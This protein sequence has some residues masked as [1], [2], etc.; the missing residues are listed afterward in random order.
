MR[1]ALCHHYS[2][3]FQ[4][5]GERFLLET[6]RQLTKRGHEVAIYALPFGKRPVN[7]LEQLEGIEYHENLM[8][9][10]RDVDIGYFI[11]APL[12]SR[13]FRGQFPRIGAL[14]A[15]VFL[16]DLQHS[17]IKNM[18]RADFI[19][20]FGYMRFLTSLYY[21]SSHAKLSEFDA[22]H[23]INRKAQSLLPE[24]KKVFYIPNWIDCSRFKPNMERN[25]GFSVLFVGRRNKGFSTYVEVANLLE[26]EEIEFNAIGPDLESTRNV[27]Y[28]GLITDIEELVKLYSSTQALV[29]TSQI[30][31]FPL[32][33]LEAA[34]CEV[35]II[36][37]QTGAIEGLDLPLLY[38]TSAEGFAKTVRDLRNMKRTN[39]QEYTELTR[40]MRKGALKYDL[41]TVFPA[42]LNML[43]E[44]ASE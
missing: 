26:G 27:K 19:R 16:N 6:A 37:L 2:L 11:Y 33:V 10:I 22:I 24:G 38:A 18:K 5:G 34:A 43:I 17:H 28:L 21:N 40:N 36:A 1:I 14:H 44:V 4:G 32:T 35:P 42:F 41:K 39:E 7:L 15:F 12:V 30:D 29:Y 25:K 20:K 9:I 31:V 3:T 13:L 8:H 23:V